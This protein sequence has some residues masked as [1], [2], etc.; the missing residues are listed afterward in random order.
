MA[1]T[2]NSLVVQGSL[3]FPPDEGAPAAQVSFGFSGP[4]TQF[5]DTR[6]VMVGAGSQA[7][8]FGSIISPGVKAFLVEYEP[9]VGG[10]PVS[11]R[12]NG[13][14]DGVEITPNGTLLHINPTPNTGITSMTLVR[15][16][17]AVVRVRLFG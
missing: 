3:Q 4:Y 14:S 1:A 16:A 7:V 6:L 11:I 15:T 13:S 12:L 8:P 17:D 5:L 2:S 9:Q 10:L